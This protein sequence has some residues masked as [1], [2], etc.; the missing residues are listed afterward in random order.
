MKV[1][2]IFCWVETG[3]PGGKPPGGEAAYNPPPLL[4]GL[5]SG[6]GS[7]SQAHLRSQFRKPRI[8]ETRALQCGVHQEPPRT[9]VFV[10]SSA[11]VEVTSGEGSL[12][13][14]QED[15]LHQKARQGPGLELTCLLGVFRGQVFGENNPSSA[16]SL[17]SST[18]KGK[19]DGWLWGVDGSEDPGVTD[20]PCPSSGERGKTRE[21]WRQ[22]EAGA[23]YWSSPSLGRSSATRSSVS[24]ILLLLPVFYLRP[25]L[26]Q[27]LRDNP[28]G[29]YSEG[30][31]RLRPTREIRPV[32]NCGVN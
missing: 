1:V 5:G 6:S 24:T 27:V 10:S 2:N 25:A 29:H 16:A 9:P 17:R 32:V 4:S 7:G 22:D 12:S 20:Q 3:V 14:R 19:M 11:S 31:H 26:G 8:V 15:T 13:R 21:Q 30:V 18:G 23:Q 28:G